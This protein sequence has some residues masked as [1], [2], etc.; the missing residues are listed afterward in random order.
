MLGFSPIVGLFGHRQVGKT[1]LAERLSDNYFSLDDRVALLLA[2]SNPSEFLKSACRTGKT[3]I[4]DECQLAPALFPALKEHVRLNKKPGQ[5]LLTGSVRYSSRKAIRESLTGRIINIMAPPLGAN[6]MCEVIRPSVLEAAITKGVEAAYRKGL[7]KDNKKAHTKHLASSTARYVTTGGLPGVC[8]VR[9]E[10]VR[11]AKLESQIETI[12]E[13]DLR[14]IFETT[15][16][17]STLR[18]V[19]VEL[20]ASVGEPLNL[21]SIQR[22]TRVSINTLKKLLGAFNAMFLMDLLPSTDGSGQPTL[23]FSDPGE[24][25]YLAVGRLSPG[26]LLAQSLYSNLMATS[27]SFWDRKVGALHLLCHRTRGGTNIPLVINSAR[28]SLGIL[29]RP[30]AMTF[31]S[32]LA[33]SKS[34]MRLK[35]AYGVIVVPEAEAPAKLHHASLVEIPHPLL[36]A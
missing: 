1:S 23:Y 18:R 27:T 14:L 5:F 29:P 28:G 32:V 3:V 31:E 11:N 2:E 22:K 26:Q 15:L 9:D 12:L 16:P 35:N 17:F 6:E 21:S 24:A 34:F 4:I 7:E 10:R 19:L 30:S 33:Q 20:A 8:F 25:T 36:I 13:R